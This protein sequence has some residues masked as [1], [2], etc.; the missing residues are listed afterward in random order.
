MSYDLRN[1]EIVHH[2]VKGQKWGVRRALGPSGHIIGSKYA[3]DDTRSKRPSAKGSDGSAAVLAIVLAAPVGLTAARAAKILNSPAS[4]KL[5][6]QQIGQTVMRTTLATLGLQ[7]L[8]IAGSLASNAN[9]HRKSKAEE[10]TKAKMDVKM[11][12]SEE[13]PDSDSRKVNPKVNAWNMGTLTNCSN[14]TLAYEMRRRGY[15][16]TAKPL[17]GGRKYEDTYALYNNPKV[18]QLDKESYKGST[19]FTTYAKNEMVNNISKYPDGARGAVQVRFKKEAMGHIFSWEKVNGKVVFKD[20]QDYGSKPEKIFDKD[21]L[22]ALSYFR[23]D[24][25]QLNM[26]LVH[27]SVENYQGGK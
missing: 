13:S 2:G 6:T 11:K 7:P 14:T 10:F 12:T 22:S 3:K 16:V 27:N 9:A 8:I 15:D 17:Y 25:A 20:H 21:V 5:K 23:T 18:K 4:G 1:C 26:N 19:K 24:N